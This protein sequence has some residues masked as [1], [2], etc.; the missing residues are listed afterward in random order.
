M[1]KLEF[2]EPSTI[3]DEEEKYTVSDAYINELHLKSLNSKKLFKNKS[4]KP[5]NN[6]HTLTAEDYNR[7]VEMA[8]QD[9]THFDVIYTQYGLNENEIK[10]LM[11]RLISP[12][13]FKRWRK[14]VQGRKTKHQKRCQ[15]KP[16]RFQGPW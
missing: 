16:T 9:R 2:N 14:R 8:W 5:L 6:K 4:I 15:H 12:K 3:H 13:A 11:R 1:I 7:I 10:K